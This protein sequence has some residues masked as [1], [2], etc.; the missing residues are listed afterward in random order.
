MTNS[1]TVG[2]SVFRCFLLLLAGMSLSTAAWSETK[3]TVMIVSLKNAKTV[4]VRATPSPDAVAIAF[5]DN[6]KPIVRKGQE[7]TDGFVMVQLEDGRTGWTKGAFLVPAGQLQPAAPGLQSAVTVPPAAIPVA[8][9]VAVQPSTI[10]ELTDVGSAKGGVSAEVLRQSP[11]AGQ[12]QMEPVSV[13]TGI[14]P[15]VAGLAGLVGLLMGLAVGGKAGAAWA[16]RSIQERYE[17]IG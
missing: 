6:G 11:P 1:V 8:K 4:A 13:K 5:V 15:W 7:E 2:G 14:S 16:T 9:P 10:P 17:M 12:A 3:A